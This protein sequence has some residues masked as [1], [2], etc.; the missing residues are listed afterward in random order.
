[1]AKIYGYVRVSTQKQSIERQIR[2]IE[3][4][5]PEAYIVND[6]FTGTKLD[7]PGWRK[8]NK[9]IKE[10][11]TIVFDSVSR[12]SRNASEGFAVY[13]EL[14]A[15][16]INL[17]FLKEPQINTGTYKGAMETTV[18]M[19]GTAVDCILEGINRYLL[20]LAKEQIR[21]AFAQS[22]KEVEDLHQRVREG[23]ITARLSGKQIGQQ[24]G[25][26]LNIR[27]AAPIKEIIR[28]KSKSFGGNNSDSEVM[29][30]L[31]GMSIEY[32]GSNGKPKKGSAKLSRNTYY[33]YKNEL[34]EEIEQ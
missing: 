23:I 18:P 29:A 12:M 30:I 25:A 28:A 22:E 33:K 5:Y 27:K 21:L 4:E 11:D 13:Q 20:E 17:V 16:G 6:R 8:L 15:K 32:L 24:Q 14:Y 2:N 26:T 7:R 10:G 1:M 19:T 3:A 9:V 34:K 31:A